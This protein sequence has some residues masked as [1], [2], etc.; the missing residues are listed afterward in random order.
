MLDASAGL[1]TR[2]YRTSGRVHQ[3]V[4]S[5]SPAARF[6]CNNRAMPGDMSAIDE[7]AVVSSF[8]EAI[9]AQDLDRLDE[10]MT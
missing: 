4:N 7:V 9:N 6:G 8:N 3:P 2:W 1:I 10:L 5:D